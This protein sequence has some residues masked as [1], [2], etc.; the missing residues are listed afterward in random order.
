MV[1]VALLSLLALPFVAAQTVHNITVGSGGL[2]FS[3]SNITASPNDT[4]VFT[5]AGTHTATESS[6]GSP[7][8]PLSNGFNFQASSTAGTPFSVTVNDT[9]PIWV[10]CAIPGHCQAGMVFAANAPTTGNTFAA[11]KSAAMGGSSSSGSST[12]GSGSGSSSPSSSA[13]ASGATTSS[14]PNGAGR[15]VAGTGATLAG[16]GALLAFTL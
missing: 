10:Y 16:L 13:A 8:A 3:P 1:N 11:F 5:F 14:K 15:V 9:N 2:V 12:S 6:F 4:I 7:C